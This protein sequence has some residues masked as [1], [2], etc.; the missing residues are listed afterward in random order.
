MRYVVLSPKDI[1]GASLSK[2]YEKH[3]VAALC[4][5][6]WLLCKGV[7]KGS[8]FLEKSEIIKKVSCVR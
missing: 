7:A 8:Y 5:R 1:T 6:W 4:I 2:Q 3:T